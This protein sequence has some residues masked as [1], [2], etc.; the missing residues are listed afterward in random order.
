MSKMMARVADG[1]IVNVIL[2]SRGTQETDELLNIPDGQKAVIGGDIVNSVFFS[3]KP[4]PSWTRG[5]TEWLPPV[6]LPDDADTVAYEW[7]EEA[8]DWVAATEDAVE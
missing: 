1:I 7:D 8:G 3:P 4:F 2:T 5:E 6:A